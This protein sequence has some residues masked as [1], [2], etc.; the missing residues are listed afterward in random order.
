MKKKLN[1]IIQY[2]GKASKFLNRNDKI[3]HRDQVRNFVVAAVKEIM[4]IE[5]SNIDLKPIKGK[6][7]GSYRI[8]T[9]Q[10]RIIF[11]LRQ[12]IISVALVESISYRKDAYR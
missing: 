4:R 6:L 10:L 3:I 1:L 5:H 2:S 9:G 7:K 11:T 12:D 8:K